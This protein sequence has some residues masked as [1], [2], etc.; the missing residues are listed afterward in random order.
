MLIFQNSQ[1]QWDYKPNFPCYCDQKR[2]QR[3]NIYVITLK[4]I[5]RVTNFS[6]GS[7][8]RDEQINIVLSKTEKK[9]CKAY[10][11]ELEEVLMGDKKAKKVCM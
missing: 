11:E 6:I 1:I 8:R 9:I 5:L 2:R 7:C 3:E 4:K 10:K